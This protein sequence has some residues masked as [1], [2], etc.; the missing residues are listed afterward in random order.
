M[1]ESIQTPQRDA[2]G[3]ALHGLSYGCAIAGS[4]AMAGLIA[5]VV[6]SVIGRALF[7]TPV[8]GDFELVSMGTALSVTLFLPYC[9]LRRGNVIVDLFLANAPQAVRSGCDVFAGLLLGAMAVLLTWRSV[10]GGIDMGMHHDVTMILAV[11]VW[12]VFPPIVLSLALLASCCL[13]TAWQ[14]LTGIRQ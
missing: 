7:S 14:D 10:L 13:Y 5:M 12:W 1:T 11:P 3:R 6:A 4:L 8:Y 2:L 9:H